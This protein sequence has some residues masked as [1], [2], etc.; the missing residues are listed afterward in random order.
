MIT[1]PQRPLSA[2]ERRLVAVGLLLLALAACW[3]LLL[4]PVLEGTAERAER[5]ELLLRERERSQ[6]LLAG[7]G[8]WREAAERQ[9][10]SAGD[11]ALQAPTPALAAEALLAR[12]RDLVA[13]QGGGTAAVTALDA[14]DRW[15]GW[16][17]ARIE[18][19]LTETQL[20]ALLRQLEAPPHLVLTDLAVSAS[21]L[22]TA[23]DQSRPVE[24][25]LDLAAPVAPAAAAVMEGR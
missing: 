3:S 24:V 21:P 10:Q 14:D 1:L 9:R 20:T 22:P 6:R 12:L 25:R 23:P 13:A 19:P 17:R 5:R 11:F 15:P 16:V 7:L 2:R 8:P 4:H 18:G